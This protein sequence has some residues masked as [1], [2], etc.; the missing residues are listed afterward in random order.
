[1]RSAAVNGRHQRVLTAPVSRAKAM[2]FAKQG[3]A[4]RIHKVIN[5]EIKMSRI[6]IS[7]SVQYHQTMTG[8]KNFAS[9]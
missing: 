4:L 1:M 5:K 6:I 3:H 9:H 2:L 7:T 8:N